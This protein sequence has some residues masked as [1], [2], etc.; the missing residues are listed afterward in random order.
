MR[1]HFLAAICSLSVSPTAYARARGH[2]AQ[3]GEAGDPDPAYGG[4]LYL[5]IWW[6]FCPGGAGASRRRVYA[7]GCLRGGVPQCGIYTIRRGQT[8]GCCEIFTNIRVL[9]G[10]CVHKPGAPTFALKTTA[11]AMLCYLTYSILSWPGIHRALITC[12]I[13]GL[14]TTAKI[15]LHHRIES[16]QQAMSSNVYNGPGFAATNLAVQRAFHLPF[17]FKRNEGSKNR[18][19]SPPASDTR[20]QGGDPGGSSKMYQ[21]QS[22]AAVLCCMLLSMLCWGSW[23][24]T[25]KL[26]TGASRQPVPASVV[27]C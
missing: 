17:R 1:V 4:G 18:R 14:G 20:D 12:F 25:R 7:A 10:R 9:R 15:S 5:P 23:A 21:P 2:A 26:T 3:Q 16:F 6:I 22:Y 13:V 8:G 24:N 27:W 19:G 11:A